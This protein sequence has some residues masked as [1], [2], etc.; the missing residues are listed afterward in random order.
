MDS[1]ISTREVGTLLPQASSTLTGTV[2]IEDIGITASTATSL[3]LRAGA[4]VDKPDDHLFWLRMNQPAGTDVDTFAD[5]TVYD[6]DI[7]AGNMTA[8]GQFAYFP[9][10]N[11]SLNISLTSALRATLDEAEGLTFALWFKLT[12]SNNG[13]NTF[14]LTG[15]STGNLLWVNTDGYLRARD[16]LTSS[17]LVTADEWHHAA[18]TFDGATSRLY[19]DGQL[20]ASGGDGKT[21][22]STDIAIGAGYHSINATYAPFYMD[23]LEVFTSALSDE[24]I[25]NSYGRAAVAADL[26]GTG[27]GVSCSGSRC[28]SLDDDGATFDQTQHLVLDTSTLNFSENQFSIAVNVTPQ[29]RSHPFGSSAASY[30]GM[31]TS[32]DWQGVYGYTSPSN[33]KLIFPSLYVGSNGALRV[34]IGDGNDACTYT[35]NDKIVTFGVEQEILVSF[36]GSAFTFYINGEERASGTSTAC[37]SI[38]IP[39]VDQ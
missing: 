24:V 2:A 39:A 10:F 26:T 6:Y 19:L 28:P 25:L 17:T 20:E 33:S 15:S 36:D 11:S 14:L 8:T 37:G 12:E 35:T 1:I 4:I 30:F 16:N 27:D 23:D 7:Y 9:V 29:T 3:T 34:V 32:Q 38:Q 31:D 5:S 21:T 18:V 22:F 13:W